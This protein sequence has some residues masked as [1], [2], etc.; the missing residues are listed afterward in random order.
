MTPR[1]LLSIWALVCCLGATAA[2]QEGRPSELAQVQALAAERERVPAAVAQLE[3]FALESADRV[4]REAAVEALGTLGG[5]EAGRALLRL[6]T[7]LPASD[8]ARAARAIAEAEGVG[9]SLS[10]LLRRSFG[11]ASAPGALDRP[12]EDAL[13]D[14]L[15]AYGTV[16]AQAGRVGPA[17]RAPL[18]EG[19]RSPSPR[20]RQAA[21]SAL[22]DAMSRF[23]LLG[24]PPAAEEWIAGLDADGLDTRELRYRQAVLALSSGGQPERAREPA[25]TLALSALG[26]DAF[27]DR[28]WGFRGHLVAAMERFAVGDFEAVEAPLA[29]ADELL[30]EL[31]SRRLELRE[32][33]DA[34]ASTADSRTAAELI[35]LQGLVS[36]MRLLNEIAAGLDPGSER[37]LLLAARIHSRLLEAQR[38]QLA[39]DAPRWANSFD[40]VL[41]RAEGPRRVLLGNPELPRWPTSALL[42]VYAAALGSLASVAPE[43]LPGIPP[44]VPGGRASWEQDPQRQALVLRLRQAERMLV[45]RRRQT[46]RI[47]R[48]LW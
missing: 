24:W 6:Y 44:A 5:R 31:R 4:V 11:P 48:Q 18:V 43:E 32:P 19:A 42:E 30:S 33:L 8:A 2:G 1:H 12:T 7:V 38:I 25:A 14:L 39:H 35:V 41:Q 17:D 10:E 36:W 16:L 9:D 37:A 29:L 45:S 47:N 34:N 3:T 21:N 20:V 46:D 28:S 40:A 27:D 13:V 22:D 26:S 23:A 15:G